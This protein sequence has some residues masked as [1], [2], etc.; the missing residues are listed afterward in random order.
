ML[1]QFLLADDITAF[2]RGLNAVERPG[3]VALHHH[4]LNFVFT[5]KKSYSVGYGYI[6]QA[7]PIPLSSFDEYK[8]VRTRI[9]SGPKSG[10][11][12]SQFPGES[13]CIALPHSSPAALGAGLG[14]N[15]CRANMAHVKTVKDRF[16][17]WLQVKVLENRFSCSLFARQQSGEPRD[18]PCHIFKDPDGRRAFWG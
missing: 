16:R 1:T 12:L 8:T 15:S 18:L 13:S 10:P 5:K 3:E 9:P 14:F 11:G 7:S 6:P 17:S 4:A 2:S